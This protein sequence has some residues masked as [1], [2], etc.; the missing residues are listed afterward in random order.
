MV[1]LGIETSCDETAAALVDSDGNVHANIVYSQIQDHE[2]YGGVVPEVAARQHVALLPN[3]LRR[4]FADSH[5]AWNEVDAIAVTRGPGLAS[6]LLIG[7][8]AAKMLAMHLEKPLLPI[9]HLEGHLCSLF[10]G[11]HAAHPDSDC[12]MLVLLVTGGHTCLIS[13]EQPGSYRMLGRTLDDAAGE[14][15]DKGA[16]LLGLS[17][18]GGP[19][20]EKAAMVGANDAMPFPVCK[21]TTK[22][23]PRGCDLNPDY[24]FSFSGVKTSLLYRL[25]R[26]K[27]DL[28][29]DITR[30]DLAA[31]YQR[32]VFDALLS[33]VE[34]A[35]SAG[36][37][38][39]LGCVGGVARNQQ[40]RE[41]LNSLAIHHGVALRIAEP[42]YCT[43]NAAMI[44][45]VPCFV[46]RAPLDEDPMNVD[47]A[48]TLPLPQSWTDP[49]SDIGTE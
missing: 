44:A 14:A 27:P 48:P 31:S 39:T 24:C 32:A 26:T 41:R 13:V 49:H 19:A 37:W 5:L 23:L 33:R 8:T 28:A 25:R 38:K 46:K 6:S 45:A 18:P 7:M 11:D 1:V 21:I 34:K 42:R 3:V 22:S 30:A 36:V 4:A 20:L 10:L 16:K 12:P 47:V 29:C 35:L 43:D 15:L 17:Y 40:L 2:P 9:H